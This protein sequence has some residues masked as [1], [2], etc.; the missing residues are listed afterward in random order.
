[1][2]A[3][4]S[5]ALLVA[6]TLTAL[7]ACGGGDKSNGPVSI[8]GTYTLRSAAGKIV[9]ATIL[10][11]MVTDPTSGQPVRHT[12]VL[13]DGTLTLSQGNSYSVLVHATETLGT[14]SQTAP[15][16]DNGTYTQSGSTLTFTSAT[17]G[18][19]VVTATLN[20]TTITASQD[21]GLGTPTTLVFQK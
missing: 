17:P 15:I 4:A 10:D 18:Q 14:Q 9:P 7:G 19:P 20:N 11:E 21:I 6:T 16:S 5:A 2:T 1:L 12:A 8:T 3:L 13:N